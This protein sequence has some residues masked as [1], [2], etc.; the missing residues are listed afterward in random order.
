MSH[1]RK[2]LCVHHTEL[3][4]LMAQRKLKTQSLPCGIQQHSLKKP[5]NNKSRDHV[6]K[7]YRRSPKDVRGGGENVQGWSTETSAGRWIDSWATRD[8]SVQA[9]RTGGFQAEEAAEL[10]PST[11]R[12]RF[13]H[14]GGTAFLD[15][16]RGVFRKSS[17]RQVSDGAR[18]WWS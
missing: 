8:S 1:T 17:K 3:G 7:R 6:T 15:W 2:P 18:S 10:S 4:A 13:P 5:P 16:N 9:Q 14:Q 11:G 12:S